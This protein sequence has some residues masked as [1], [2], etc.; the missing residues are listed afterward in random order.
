[1]KLDDIRR[2]YLYAGLSR[3][4][5]ADDPIVQFKNWLQTAIDADLNADPTAMSLATVNAQGVPSQRIVLL[6][7]LDPSG[8]VFYTN[9]GSR[10]AQNIA[11]NANVS[12]HFAWLPMERQI[13]VTGVAEKLSIAEATRYFL[14]RPH[15]S[16]VAA[17]ASQQSQG[18]GSRK[19]LEQAFEQMKNRFKQGEV[20]L[21]SF[22]GGYRV[23]PVTIE[24][25]QGRANRLHDRFLYKKTDENWEIER[26]Q[27]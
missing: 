16:Q 6:K 1:M 20:P 22:W 9:L 12:L 4:D 27:P 2:E 5:L 11:E 18:I 26:L 17:W 3:K 8:F 10:K 24:F 13:C 7:N 19:L 21:P 25:W 23:K 15:E 14:S